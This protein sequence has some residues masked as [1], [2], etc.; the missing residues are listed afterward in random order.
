MSLPIL[1][2]YATTHGAT[3]EVA[4]AIATTLRADGID[5]DCQPAKNVLSLDGYRAVV[6][7]APL[8]MF[9]WHKDAKRFLEQHRQLLVERPLAIF[10]LGPFHDE[11]KEFQEA[12]V[13]L[14]KDLLHFPWLA[15]VAV[16]MFGGKLD[17]AK[18]HLP[19]SLIPALKKMPPSDIRDWNAIQAW[20]GSL[21]EKLQ[22]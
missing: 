11:E 7:G 1:I 13:Q 22:R 15:P 20:A 14:D 3:Q 12:R 10:A 8:Y 16:E 17:P 9:H 19:Y 2:A 5:V 6:L 21:T 4:E 18:L